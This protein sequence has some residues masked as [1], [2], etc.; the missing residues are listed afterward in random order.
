MQRAALRKAGCTTIATDNGISC[1][2]TNRP[3]LLG[4]LKKLK[5]GDLALSE[6]VQHRYQIA[7]AAPG[8]SAPV[9][10][11]FATFPMTTSGIYDQT[12]DLSTFSFGGGLNETS[13]ITGLESG[14]AYVNIHDVNFPS[15][16]IRGQLTAVTPEPGSLLLLATG[17][18][19]LL[20]IARR[21]LRV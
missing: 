15:G 6:V 21:G 8:A 17:A 10:V 18:L 5:P 3:A 2:T 4:T 19:G 1:A 7:Q 9:V 11:P 20:D 12:F 14:L 13:F 16:E